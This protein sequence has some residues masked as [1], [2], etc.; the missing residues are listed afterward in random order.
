MTIPAV[1]AEAPLRLRNLRRA[2][3]GGRSRA[4]PCWTVAPTTS[5]GLFATGTAASQSFCRRPRR[6]PSGLQHRSWRRRARRRSCR[7]TQSAS[8]SSSDSCPSAL[9][10]SSALLPRLCGIGGDVEAA[11]CTIAR[12]WR[13]RET[14]ARRRE[15]RVWPE[16]PAEELESE[17]TEAVAVGHG[18]RAQDK[19]VK[20]VAAKHRQRSRRRQVRLLASGGDTTVGNVAPHR[21]TFLSRPV[22][23]RLGCRTAADDREAGS[24]NSDQALFFPQTK[25]GDALPAFA[26]QG[27]PLQGPW[28]L[29]THTQ[30]FSG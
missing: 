19:S 2:V 8:S 23:G 5:S 10:R 28:K 3:L 9:A 7:R 16:E 26:K 18:N 17:A 24:R 21:G 27:H 29:L 14:G 15:P 13:P 11:G 25:G 4:W 6:S 12:S 1:Q 22:H 20:L 30:T